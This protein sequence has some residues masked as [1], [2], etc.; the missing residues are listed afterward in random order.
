M[1]PVKSSY[2]TTHLVCPKSYLCCKQRVDGFPQG[3]TSD[4]RALDASLWVGA[5]GMLTRPSR[6]HERLASLDASPW[7][8]ALGILAAAKGLLRQSGHDGL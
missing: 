3:H 5:L 1:Q 7:V 4:S 6:A 2:K 8:G